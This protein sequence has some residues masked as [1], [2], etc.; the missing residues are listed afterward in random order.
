MDHER[1]VINSDGR[2]RH[3]ALSLDIGFLEADCRPKVLAGL[4]AMTHQ[5]LDIALRVGCYCCVISKLHISNEYFADLGVGSEA[6]E[7][8]KPAI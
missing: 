4:G 3:S 5:G 2:R 7:I 1:I 8:E 6:G